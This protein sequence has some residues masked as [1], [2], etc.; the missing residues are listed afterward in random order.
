MPIKPFNVLNQIISYISL[1]SVSL[2]QFLTGA[3]YFTEC[4]VLVRGLRV[5]WF[6][7]A[8]EMLDVY[9]PLVS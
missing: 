1:L 5:Y 9:L 3:G 7:M 8:K 4:V 6:K 2:Q